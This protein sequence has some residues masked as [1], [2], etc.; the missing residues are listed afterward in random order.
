MA[1][2]HPKDKAEF[3]KIIEGKKPVL[4][5]FFAQWCGPC[6]MMGPIFDD[7]AKDYKNADKVEIMKVDVDQLQ[8]VARDL[9]IMSV[10]TF[11]IFKGGKV[12]ETMTGMRSQFDLEAK[13]DAQLK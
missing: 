2:V 12:V 10:P 3:D 4:V 11:V 6:Q 8:D 9:A 13:L 1:I 5:D 7:L